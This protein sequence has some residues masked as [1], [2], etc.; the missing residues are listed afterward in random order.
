MRGE[1]DTQPPQTL[2]PWPAN[3]NPPL[4]RLWAGDT[5][6]QYAVIYQI[7]RGDEYIQTMP[8]GDN[9]TYTATTSW[10]PNLR[11]Y[12]TESMF[13]HVIP[14]P[15]FLSTAIA[16][17]LGPEVPVN[18]EV[19]AQLDDTLALPA[20]PPNTGPVKAELP[21]TREDYPFGDAY[22]GAGDKL[23]DGAWEDKDLHVQ[24][25]LGLQPRVKGGRPRSTRTMD[26][27]W[28]HKVGYGLALCRHTTD[29]PRQQIL[30]AYHFDTVAAFTYL[31]LH[32]YP[33]KSNRL[34]KLASLK[35]LEDYLQEGAQWYVYWPPTIAGRTCSVDQLAASLRERIAYARAGL[36]PSPVADRV[37]TGYHRVT[38]QLYAVRQLGIGQGTAPYGPAA[39]WR[40]AGDVPPALIRRVNYAQLSIQRVPHEQLEGCTA[41]VVFTACRIPYQSAESGRLREEELLRFE[42][43][44]VQGFRSSG[45]NQDWPPE[46]GLPHDQMP[47]AHLIEVME[48]YLGIFPDPFDGG[49]D[50]TRWPSS[51]PSVTEDEPMITVDQLP[52]DA[53]EASAVPAPSIPV[54]RTPP[55]RAGTPAPSPSYALVNKEQFNQLLA[56]TTQL[57]TPGRS[58]HQ[59]ELPT[60]GSD[61][62]SVDLEDPLV[63][64]L[65]NEGLDAGGRRP[66]D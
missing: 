66:E 38:S 6:S 63:Q 14:R 2:P 51:Q 59:T 65:L 18:S 28:A 16:N 10:G 25:A 7:K 62:S 5:I 1:F 29:T 17:R 35:D 61:S 57:L 64:R 22:D 40:N 55:P 44:L 37:V 23:Y 47:L 13:R 58:V 50:P 39:I 12:E 26:P 52:S 36:R 3:W 41:L 15:R 24:K 4:A 56:A 45:S 42:D 11:G 48:G 43:L 60:S 49:D 30:N 20:A 33:Q 31:Q 34:Q 27:V 21:L 32:R 46:A 19:P 53:T 54:M 9:R 8:L